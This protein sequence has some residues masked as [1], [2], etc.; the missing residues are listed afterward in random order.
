MQE[1]NILDYSTE[2]LKGLPKGVFLNAKAGDKKNVMTIGWMTLG[3]QW[4]QTCLTIMVRPSRF[5]NGLIQANPVL[6]V[7]SPIKGDFKEAVAI[8]GTKSG[9]DMDKIA[10]CNFEIADAETIDGFIV[11]GCGLHV[12]CEIADIRQMDASFRNDSIKEAWY[13]EEDWH[14]YYTAV[15]N[16]AYIE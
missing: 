12:E 5:T 2:V 13:K 11:K 4:N 3:R 9:R 10:A 14:Y 16:K 8:C 15:G 7:S 6:T 1:V